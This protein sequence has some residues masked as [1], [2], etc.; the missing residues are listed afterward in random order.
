MKRK[1]QWKRGPKVRD[2]RIEQ[3]IEDNVAAIQIQVRKCRLAR[4][5]GLVQILEALGN[6][7]GDLD[8]YLPG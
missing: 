5:H 2:P 3:S 6:A 8:P 4:K 7:A 1:R